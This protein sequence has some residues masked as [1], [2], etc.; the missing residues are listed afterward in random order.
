M[1]K[2]KYKTAAI[3]FAVVAVIAVICFFFTRKPDDTTNPSQTAGVEESPGFPI[4]TAG[5]G[6]YPTPAPTTGPFVNIPRP[7]SDPDQFQ[8]YEYTGSNYEKDAVYRND[9]TLSLIYDADG[10]T[11]SV[12]LGDAA[13]NDGLYLNFQE[14]SGQK[15][16]YYIS[17]S[18]NDVLFNPTFDYAPMDSEQNAPY[19]NFLI[20]NTYDQLVP[21]EGN[22]LCWA[23]DILYDGKTDTGTILYVRAVN[24]PSGTIQA[25][26]Q[27]EIGF[28]NGQYLIKSI[29]STDTVSTGGMTQED[30]DA[31]VK[32][33]LALATN[34]FLDLDAL[35]ADQFSKEDEA[36]VLA[37]S[38]VEKV[39]A[40]YFSMVL[41][42]PSGRAVRSYRISDMHDTIYAVTLSSQTGDCFTLY[43]SADATDSLETLL[44]EDVEEIYPDGIPEGVVL[45]D[46]SPVT[47]KELRFFA[48]DLFSPKSTS[49][50]APSGYFD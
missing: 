37:Y 20:N 2:T 42:P 43:Y 49:V 21:A 29:T 15:M 38:K 10:S 45:P 26:F 24:L 33:A 32:D 27:I 28:E 6:V 7:S 12:G 25:V 23:N 50:S 9:Q 11:I 1:N 46:L 36:M 14:S 13:V 40:P 30:H 22:I 39:D 47:S 17:S 5:P 19:S 35:A 44:Q 16:G 18:R 48:Y 8:D 3:L 34:Q 31:L 4:V 41:T